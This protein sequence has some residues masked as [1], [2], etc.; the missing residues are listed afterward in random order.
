MW[1]QQ[2]CAQT[3]AIES[4]SVPFVANDQQP[5]VA[6][7]MLPFTQ[8]LRMSR[9]PTRLLASS[10]VT[11]KFFLA[12]QDVTVALAGKGKKTGHFQQHYNRSCTNNRLQG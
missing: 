1:N 4:R 3:K 6:N 10:T 7:V 11:T 2:R 5:A 9:V 12:W 8:S